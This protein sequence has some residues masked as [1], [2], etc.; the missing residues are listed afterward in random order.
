[1]NTDESCIVD[2]LLTESCRAVVQVLYLLSLNL[3]SNAYQRQM[4]CAYA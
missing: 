4:T 3:A 2:T 1:M